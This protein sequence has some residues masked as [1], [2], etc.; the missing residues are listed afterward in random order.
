MIGNSFLKVKRFST[1]FIN[2]EVENVPI[3]DFGR[4]IRWQNYCFGMEKWNSM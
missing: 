4:V 1:Q 2:I 3:L